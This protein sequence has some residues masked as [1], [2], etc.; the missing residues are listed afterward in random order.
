MSDDTDTGATEPT[1][2]DPLDGDLL[3]GGDAPLDVSSTEAT[4]AGAAFESVDE[5][6]P[7]ETPDPGVVPKAAY[8]EGCEHFADP[9]EVACTHEGTRIAELVDREHFRVV[10]CPVVAEREALG[11]H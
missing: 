11:D 1:A 5:E 10:D 4:D 7:Q 6:T 3:V 8:C 9:P 2:H